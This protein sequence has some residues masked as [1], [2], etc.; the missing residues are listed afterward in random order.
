ME[1]VLGIACCGT[2]NDELQRL[3]AKAVRVAMLK[4]CLLVR[5][6]DKCGCGRCADSRAVQWED[7]P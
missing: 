6:G 5:A 1:A 2:Y 3:L 7:E 4:Y